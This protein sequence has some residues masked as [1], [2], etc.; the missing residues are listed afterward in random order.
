MSHAWKLVALIAIVVFAQPVLALDNEGFDDRFDVRRES[1]A[2]SGRNEFVVLEPGYQLTLEGD[3]QGKLARLVITVLEKTKTVDGVETRVVE[4]R[5]SLADQLVEVS[6]NYFAID[7]NS[8]DVYYFGEEVDIYKNG[9][10]T[11][12]DG[13]WES[14]KNGAHY[15]LFMPGGPRT[16]QKF[17]QELA[18]TVAMDR[19]EVVGMRET[20]KVPAGTFDNCARIQETTPL[21]PATKEQKVYARGVGLLSDGVMKLVKYGNKASD[22]QGSKRNAQRSTSNAP[23]GTEKADKEPL[24]PVTMAR[25]ALALVG[26]DPDAEAVWKM[27]I[28]DPAL[29]PHERQDL[30]EDLNED[31]FADPKNV[32]PDELPL[33]LSRIDLIEQMAP[34]A[35]DET[36]ADAFE[37]AHKDL[38]NIAAR[39]TK[40]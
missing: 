4:E 7:K 36:N 37:E 2:S 24:V 34:D 16:G 23:D 21:E 5:E 10:I 12:H 26:S 3:N 40:Q 30:I 29:T 14:G 18:P 27:A 22:G 31:G 35:M 28:N 1:F 38:V 25:E 33:V 19:C 15:G 32:T 6:R 17:Y 9:K 13:A 8:K 20:M 11:S 39:L